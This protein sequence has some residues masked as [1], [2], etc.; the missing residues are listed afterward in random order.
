M[1]S[2]AQELCSPR[3][4][5]APCPFVTGAD[6]KDEEAKEPGSVTRLWKGESTGGAE[7]QGVC[8][9]SDAETEDLPSIT[10]ITPTENAGS[11]RQSPHMALHS[12]GHLCLPGELD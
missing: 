11:F 12:H 7:C 8:A 3:A 6:C 2:S 10:L 1:E 5:P 4:A 9:G